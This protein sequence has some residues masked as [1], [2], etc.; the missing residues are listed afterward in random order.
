MSLSTI[1]L[2]GLLYE[3][4]TDIAIT[5]SL[6]ALCLF[7]YS[8]PR[9]SDN[10]GGL[11]VLHWT[12]YAQTKT[13]HPDVQGSSDLRTPQRRKNRHANCCRARYSSGAIASMEAPSSGQLSSFIYRI[14][15]SAAPSSRTRST[16]RRI[17]CSNW[18]THDAT[19]V[20]QKKIWPRP[21]LALNGCN[22]WSHSPR[23]YR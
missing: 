8:G 20:A 22:S 6:E 18:E 11:Q 1:E 10:L 2:N 14:L 19:R 7:E 21:F 13:L 17:V 5:S 15:R 23:A 3:C 16:T 4:D 12:R 9:N